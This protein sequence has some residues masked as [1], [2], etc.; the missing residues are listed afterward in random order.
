VDHH[1]SHVRD[2]YFCR[3]EEPPVDIPL[4]QLAGLFRIRIAANA[5]LNFPDI[6][7]GA[8][9]GVGKSFV[10]VERHVVD[11]IILQP[12]A[13]FQRGN[14]S[15]HVFLGHLNFPYCEILSSVYVEPR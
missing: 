9:I 1:D 2:R 3:R 6:Y 15:S 8:R 14:Q 7:G 13:G 4:K 10:V 11:K 12:R 5:F